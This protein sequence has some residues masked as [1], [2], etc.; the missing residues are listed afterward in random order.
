MQTKERKTFNNG[1]EGQK[2]KVGFD[3][4]FIRVDVM[5]MHLAKYE[6]NIL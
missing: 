6:S 3:I 5:V 2:A 1:H 4:F